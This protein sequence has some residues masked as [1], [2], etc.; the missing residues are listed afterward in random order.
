MIILAYVPDCHLADSVANHNQC[1]AENRPI[2]DLHCHSSR[3]KVSTYG[4]LELTLLKGRQR[5]GV[6]STSNLEVFKFWDC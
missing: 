3:N 2:L 4:Y 5:F 1:G 6:V